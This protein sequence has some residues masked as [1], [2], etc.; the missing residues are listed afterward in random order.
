MNKV[1]KYNTCDPLSQNEHKVAAAA[2]QNN[3]RFKFLI[4]QAL[5]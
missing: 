4:M 2:F 3:Y 1:L 5:I